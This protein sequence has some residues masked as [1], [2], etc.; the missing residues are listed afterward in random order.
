L[1]RRLETTP[2]KLSPVFVAPAVSVVFE[3]ADEPEAVVLTTP[4]VSPA[5][6]EV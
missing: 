4:V 1:E 2:T 6:L 3:A 5:P